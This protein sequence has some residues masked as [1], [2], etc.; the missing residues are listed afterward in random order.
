M[1]HGLLDCQYSLQVGTVIK[2][3]MNYIPQQNFVNG[4]EHVNLFLL[5]L[6]CCFKADHDELQTLNNSSHIF[7]KKYR[8]FLMNALLM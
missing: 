5:L 4:L 1:Q 2:F 7:G 8:I 6:S 3:E